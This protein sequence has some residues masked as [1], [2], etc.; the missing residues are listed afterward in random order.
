MKALSPLVSLAMQMQTQPG[1]MA[2]LLG[3]GVSTG[4]GLPTGWEIVKD[5]SPPCRGLLVAPTPYR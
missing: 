1:V 5:S 3:S 4:A 2:V